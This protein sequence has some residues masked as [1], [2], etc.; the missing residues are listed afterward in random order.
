MIR[1]PPRATR[2][3]TLFPCTT[4]CRGPGRRPARGDAAA[5]ARRGRDRRRAEGLEC[6]RRGADAARRSET[7]DPLA[8]SE[9]HTSELQLLMRISYVV[10]CSKKQNYI[11]RLEISIDVSHSHT[12]QPAHKLISST[13]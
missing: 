12:P 4:L 5:R 6:R 13:M 10:F 3:D 8:R 7:G 11:T 1:R 2:T 9:E